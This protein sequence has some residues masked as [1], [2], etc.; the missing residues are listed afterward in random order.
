QISYTSREFL[1]LLFALC[2][3]QLSFAPL[4]LGPLIGRRSA[5]VATVSSGWALVILAG[6]TAVGLIAVALYASTGREPWL[7]AAVPACLASG[8]VLFMLA[9]LL[10]GEGDAMAK[11]AIGPAPARRR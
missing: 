10:A 3:A 7:W 4:L 11:S 8:L 6:G 9:Q 5:R 2:C 1:G